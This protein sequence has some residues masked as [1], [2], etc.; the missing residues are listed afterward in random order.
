M[1]RAQ[2]DLEA[3]RTDRQESYYSIVESD[4]EVP[5]D[6]AVCFEPRYY[7]V[8]FSPFDVVRWASERHAAGLR[9]AIY[10]FDLV[11]AKD[12]EAD[13][14]D[15]WRKEYGDDKLPFTWDG[16]EDEAL[17]EELGQ[18][19]REEHLP[20]SEFLPRVR[21]RYNW[22]LARFLGFGA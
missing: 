11:T 1:S 13:A 16:T 12:I 7:D 4:S 18:P 3:K 9:S 19:P 15:T 8:Y 20:F 6:K 2:W 14:M 21:A 5:E 17:K 22:N 10:N